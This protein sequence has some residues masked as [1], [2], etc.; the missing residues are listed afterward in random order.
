[1]ADVIQPAIFISTGNLLNI[2]GETDFSA[3]EIGNILCDIIRMISFVARR[4]PIA[5]NSCVWS[6]FEYAIQ[7]DPKLAD[8]LKGFVPTNRMLAAISC[9][10]NAH[11]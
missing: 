3:D 4:W 1:M 10:D 9:S 11:H 8:K 2:F 5:V 6:D 7:T